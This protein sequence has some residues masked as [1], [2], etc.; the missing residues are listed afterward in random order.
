MPLVHSSH[1]CTICRQPKS[2]WRACPPPPPGHRHLPIAAPR[3]AAASAAHLLPG[4]AVCRTQPAHSRIPARRSP[5]GFPGKGKREEGRPG[6]P[7]PGKDTRAASAVPQLRFH[8]GQ[9]GEEAAAQDSRGGSRL[10]AGGVKRART[11]RGERGALGRAGSAGP[12]GAR[13]D[14]EATRETAQAAETCEKGEGGRTDG[15]TAPRAGEGGSLR[16]LGAQGGVPGGQAR[17]NLPGTSPGGRGVLLKFG[18]G[19]YG[20]EKAHVGRGQARRVRET[21]EE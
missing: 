4:L 2:P 8:S 17:G 20:S 3:V 16:V 9:G 12:A 11:P 5:P 10:G 15:Q 6:S 14:A 19:G 1:S 7:A 21:R 18:A 13:R